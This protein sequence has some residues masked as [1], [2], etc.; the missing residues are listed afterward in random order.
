MDGLLQDRLDRL[1]TQRLEA[2]AAAVLVLLLVIAAIL[3]RPGGRRRAM[4]PVG[5]GGE[6]TRD[7]PL[8][9]PGQQPSYANL[10]DPSP[11]YGEA[12]PTRRERSGALR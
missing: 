3:L 8:R 12:D 2:I 7:M 11:S 5:G 1:D 9:Q 6:T 4:P 10:I